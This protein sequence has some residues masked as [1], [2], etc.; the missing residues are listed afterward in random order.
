MK[1]AQLDVETQVTITYH[2]IDTLALCS[3]QL[4]VWSKYNFNYGNNMVFSSK[5]NMEMTRKAKL[6]QK[7]K[8]KNFGEIFSY[9]VIQERT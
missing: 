2:F 6:L 7:N 4:D 5:R 8:I 1:K 9:D 3:K